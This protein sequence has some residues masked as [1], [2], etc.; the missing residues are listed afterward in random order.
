[1]IVRGMLDLSGVFVGGRY[2]KAPCGCHTLQLHLL[3]LVLV[4][5]CDFGRCANT[6]RNGEFDVTAFAANMTRDSSDRLDEPTARSGIRSVF[7]HLTDEERDR[8]VTRLSEISVIATDARDEFHAR[9]KCSDCGARRGTSKA[10]A[11]CSHPSTFH[12]WTLNR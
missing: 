1:V 10:M 5:T 11:D 9:E 12:S 6:D 4:F 7:S 2:S 8:M 3:V